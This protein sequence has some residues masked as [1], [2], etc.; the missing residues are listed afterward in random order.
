MAVSSSH[1]MPW[2][3]N[4]CSLESRATSLDMAEAFW[5]RH[6]LRV[7]VFTKSTLIAVS[8]TP[9]LEKLGTWELVANAM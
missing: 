4:S 7:E 5:P 1:Q 8:K 6:H 9:E 2:C 3:D